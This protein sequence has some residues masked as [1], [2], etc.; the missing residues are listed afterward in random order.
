M[1][2]RFRKS[3]KIAPGVRLN[4]NKKS[5]S[6]SFGGKGFHH[7]ISSTGRRT[8]TTGLPG[9]GISYSTTES[10]HKD[11]GAEPSTQQSNPKVPN[12]GQN[13]GCSGC[14]WVLLALI[15]WPFALSYW[16]WTSNKFHASKKARVGI[17]AAFWAVLLVFASI[18]GD[19]N[20][21]DATQAS[22]MPTATVAAE[23]PQPTT[24][25]T[26][27][28][29]SEPTAVPTEVPTPEPTVAPTETPTPQP[30]EVPATESISSTTSTNSSVY[31]AGMVYIASRGSGKKYHRIPSCSGMD[32]ATAVTLE[33]AEAWGYTPCKRCY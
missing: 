16:L 20:A 8:T 24:I 11:H 26:E 12:N 7:T 6:V 22:P 25:P 33:Q 15:F 32:N 2:F 9:T 19:S 17:I 14:L 18:G 29:A 4:L 31:Q 30:T 21:S 5:T 27:A 23:T 13:K 10:V 28:P 1:A 3:V